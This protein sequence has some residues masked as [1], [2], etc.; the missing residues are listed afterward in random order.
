MHDLINEIYAK[1]KA[2]DTALSQF[3]KRGEEYAA[4]ERDY[5]IAL[6]KKI[7]M[8]RDKSTPVTIISDIC[9]GSAEIA[10]LRFKRDVAEVLYKS[11]SEA[12]NSYKLQL[13]LL[14]AQMDREKGTG[15]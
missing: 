15:G 6:S 1:T 10:D 2:L 14:D 12:I 11:A 4:S 5:K 7:L 13:R 3:R 8:E 9:R